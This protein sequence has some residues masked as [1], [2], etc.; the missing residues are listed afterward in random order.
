[1]Q[2]SRNQFPCFILP[3]SQCVLQRNLPKQNQE[4]SGFSTQITQL[5]HLVGVFPVTVICPM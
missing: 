1:M 4:M 3:T 5:N 2:K